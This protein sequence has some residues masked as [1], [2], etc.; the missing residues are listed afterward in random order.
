MTAR[1]ANRSKR[2]HWNG[3]DPNAR[4]LTRK[5]EERR[6]KTSGPALGGIMSG[7]LESE[8]TGGRLDNVVM[9]EDAVL[10]RLLNINHDLRMTMFDTTH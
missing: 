4:E 1:E 5:A 10:R 6:R 8:I 9:S 7:C 2:L 3:A